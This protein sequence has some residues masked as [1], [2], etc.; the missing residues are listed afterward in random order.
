MSASKREKDEDQIEMSKFN[1]ALQNI[2]LS[3]SKES[4]SE[5]QFFLAERNVLAIENNML[6]VRLKSLVICIEYAFKE[7]N[8]KP[9]VQSEEM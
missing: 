4:S 2:G 8:I 3:I 6:Y 7:L 5:L 9:P 1:Y